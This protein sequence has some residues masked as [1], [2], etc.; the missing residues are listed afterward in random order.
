[1]R[2]QHAPER[3]PAES[4]PLTRFVTSL[5]S[6]HGAEEESCDHD[7]L[8]SRQSHWAMVSNKV[9]WSQAVVVFAIAT[10]PSSRSG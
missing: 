8:G 9:A 10:I 3:P 7:H 5:A 6:T 2:Q 4:V 1:M